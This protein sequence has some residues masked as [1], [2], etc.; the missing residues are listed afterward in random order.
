MYVCTYSKKTT[1]LSN[2]AGEA[3][4]MFAHHAIKLLFLLHEP[5]LCL[6]RL[7]MV[8]KVNVFYKVK[9]VLQGTLFLLHE[10]LLRLLR[11]HMV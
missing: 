1:N 9:Y 7:H 8:Y 10:P 11:L 2:V 6:L 3:I 5:L 4:D